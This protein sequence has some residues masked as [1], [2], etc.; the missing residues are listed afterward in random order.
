M[1][2]RHNALVSLFVAAILAV[3]LGCLVVGC[4]GGASSTTT[5]SLLT[6]PLTTSSTGASTTTSVPTEVE[7][8]STFK[9]KDP[10]IPQAL[11]PT[12]TTTTLAATTTTTLSGTST[13]STTSFSGSTTTTAQ[14]STTT[15]TQATT[16]TTA[17]HGT[18]NQLHSLKI[19]SISTVNG[20][21]VVT[22]QVDST[23]YSDLHKGDTV[24]T[25]FGQIKVLDINAS[26][27]TVT[28][29]QGSETE[30]LSVGQTVLK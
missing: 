24:S 1:V 17:P 20:S 19:L 21:P 23:V 11:P 9:S 25:S 4:M 10:F 14:G 5:Q 15:T 29:L 7:A 3:A 26:S 2:L 30:L 27:Q 8:L 12:T 16:T 28:L 22:F 13:T 18:N 6:L